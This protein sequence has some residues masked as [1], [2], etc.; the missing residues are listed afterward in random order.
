LFGSSPNVAALQ[1]HA[2]ALGGAGE[3]ALTIAHQLEETSHHRY[4]SGADIAE[5]YCALGQPDLAM[6]WLDR[7][8]LNRDKAMDMISI[9]PLFDGCRSDR[10]FQE[11]VRKLRLQPTA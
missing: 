7:G 2:L 10:R 4:V 9:E 6:R 11:L 5:V 3:Q 1:G 8:Y